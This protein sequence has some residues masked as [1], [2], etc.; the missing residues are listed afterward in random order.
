M[1]PI[2]RSRD[3]F[4]LVELLVVIT[5]IGILIALLLP[6]VQAAREAARQMRCA[7]HLKQLILAF[8]N[9][10]DLNHRFPPGA[11]E[12][13][14]NKDGSWN[15]GPGGSWHISI[16]PYMEQLPL[17]NMIPLATVGTGPNGGP[18][19]HVRKQNRLCY[20]RVVQR[21]R[22]RVWKGRLVNSSVPMRRRLCFRET[23]SLVNYSG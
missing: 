4:T 12:G 18:I 17:Y 11:F 6:A 13:H 7:N 9:Y 15:Y 14:W 19:G 2:R 20:R 8:H 22:L 21:N 16:L 5:I 23:R 1:L 10:H 3:G